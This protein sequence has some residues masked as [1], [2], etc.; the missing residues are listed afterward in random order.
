MSSASGGSEQTVY[1]LSLPY[2]ALKSGAY[3]LH[4][5]QSQVGGFGSVNLVT[6][7]SAF[8]VRVPLPAPKQIAFED[9]TLVWSSVPNARSYQVDIALPDGTSY[10][11][12]TTDTRL[13]LARL[14][15]S[16][17]FDHFTAKVSGVD[18]THSVTGK[19][20]VDD[21]KLAPKSPQW[22]R[23]KIEVAPGSV[24]LRWNKV[25]EA[26]SYMIEW[27][28]AKKSGT[29]A[30]FTEKAVLYLPAGRYVFTVQAVRK[31][32]HSAPSAEYEVE[33]P[34]GSL[35][36]G[37]STTGLRLDVTWQPVLGATKY[38]V[39]VGNTED[40][41]EHSHI[42]TV[43]DTRFS[44]T[45]APGTYEV[46]VD[47]ESDQGTIASSQGT[48]IRLALQK[49]SFKHAPDTVAA[50]AKFTLEWE[51]VEGASRYVL[52]ELRRD[53]N[54]LTPL[55]K[56]AC[57]QPWRTFISERSWDTVHVFQVEPFDSNDFAGDLS[58][59]HEIRFEKPATEAPPVSEAAER[60][61]HPIDEP[62]VVEPK[63]ARH[64]S[65]RYI[66]WNPKS[67]PTLNVERIAGGWYIAWSSVSGAT[68]YDLSIR[69]P[70]SNTVRLDGDTNEFTLS[71]SDV[72]G[73]VYSVSVTPYSEIEAQ[74]GRKSNTVI[75]N[76]ET[77]GNQNEG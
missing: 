51:E 63:T 30:S 42:E 72:V 31:N 65:R 26:D 27:R 34:A 49:P 45:F 36:L 18:P 16:L 40:A 59:M 10:Q 22:A 21:F 75:I 1:I 33:I 2:S 13:D 58:D 48:T 4:L 66:V 11:Q 25:S 70:F 68:H 44:K 47:A 28:S 17:D 39:L 61:E 19:P 29:V 62:R 46:Y 60:P 71:D 37:V 43:T 6:R 57:A 15:I 41:G 73:G 24:T 32:Q 8:D 5:K 12:V 64:D 52:H 20:I 76:T 50:G 35:Q 7:T 67:T 55:N 54:T 3:R 74:A 14:H 77:E 9:G 56:W 53:D 69:G 23:K 38:T